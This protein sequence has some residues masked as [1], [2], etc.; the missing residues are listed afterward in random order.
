MIWDLYLTECRDG[1][2]YTGITTDVA[3][4]YKAHVEGTDVRHTR[5][6]PP[7]RLLAS[8]PVGTR[9]HALKHRGTRTGSGDLT[10]SIP[11]SATKGAHMKRK[12]KL[13][14]RNPLVSPA[15]F[16][17]A[18]IHRKTRKAERR[19][20]QMETA[21][22]FK[23]SGRRGDTRT[24]SSQRGSCPGVVRSLGKFMPAGAY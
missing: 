6:H 23:H 9:S 4:R 16:R 15:L 20:D 11:E 22:L 24:M 10:R 18:G 13:A 8:V 7:A 3:K 14:P 17:K 12:S 19:T 21:T 5:S 2:L 1:S